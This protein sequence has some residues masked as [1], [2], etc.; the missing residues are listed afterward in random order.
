[1][2]ACPSQL[3]VLLVLDES[4]LLRLEPEILLP[5]LRGHV[6]FSAQRSVRACPILI[7]RLL[8]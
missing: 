5:L 1:M 4:F 6:T 8:W 3:L 7:A 2:F